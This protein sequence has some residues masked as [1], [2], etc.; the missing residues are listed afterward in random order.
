MRVLIIDNETAFIKQLESLF[1][2]INHKII[3]YKEVALEEI[4]RYSHIILSGGHTK[5]TPREFKKELKVIKHTTIPLLGI[6]LGH[7]LICHAFGARLE[8]L[9]NREVGIIPIE[10]I[11]KDL[12]FKGIKRMNIQAYENHIYSVHKL[13]KNLIPLAK[14]KDGY[15]IIR[16]KNKTIYGFQFHPEMFTNKTSG[17][18]LVKNFLEQTGRK[19][20]I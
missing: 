4:K 20:K 3:N 17:T 5:I 6:C 1:Q 11:Q 16:H 15:E 7:Q 19:T 18:C 10:I 14:S 9:K 8:K 2:R 13:G 12:I